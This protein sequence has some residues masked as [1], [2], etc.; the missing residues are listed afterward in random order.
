VAKIDYTHMALKGITK[1]RFVVSQIR[2]W[3][4]EY[5]MVI[6]AGPRKVGKT[7]ALLQLAAE[8]N[9][10]G[11]VYLNCAI[12]S[13]ANQIENLIDDGFRGLLLLDEFHMLDDPNT[14][15]HMF[16]TFGEQNPRFRVVLT[17]SVSSSMILLAQMKGGGRNRLL[18]IPLLTY[19]EY[20][21]FTDRIS[22]YNVD[23]TSV[24]FG[25]SF[26]DYISL[27][28]LQG[29]K[30][31]R[32][33]SSYITDASQEIQLAREMSSYLASLLNSNESDIQRAL[34]LLAYKL[35]G[36][37][38]LD[39]TFK[40]PKVG[41]FEIGR[42]TVAEQL[43]EKNIFSDFSVWKATHPSMGASQIEE[44]LRYLLW[45]EL[46]LC[47]FAMEDINS[48]LDLSFLTKL[49]L[50]KSLSENDLRRFF[51]PDIQLYVVNPLWY[52]LVAEELWFTLEG[53][54]T[55]NK[56]DRIFTKLARLL[57]DRNTFLEDPHIIGNWVEAYLRGAYAL[58]RATPLVTASFQDPTGKEIDIVQ[59]FPVN[60]LIEVAVKTR[61][62]K[63]KD[64]NFH[65]AYTGIEKCFVTTKDILE[66]VNWNG[67]PIWRI[68]YPM[69]A[70]FLD[71]GEV[72]SEEV[73]LRG[74]GQ[75]RDDASPRFG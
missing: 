15:M 14:Y 5:P 49:Y 6:L 37:W 47:N 10:K 20:L 2:R 65:L 21:Y 34:L 19:L 51:S 32:I 29:F 26:L 18:H 11:A 38:D 9:S 54:V 35:T 70:V 13:D 43:R 66:K 60:V 67:V 25:D 3:L 44:S 61:E 68:P 17:G 31:P 23:L 69:L 50:G 33:D 72:P 62:K 71:R 4:P 39:Q 27:K 41:N 53:L 52:S 45:S 59:G 22:D 75:A 8:F 28:D 63:A 57:K 46:A 40:N 42:A 30:L 55:T 24:D 64:V 1:E 12:P 16:N 7:V 56:N 74:S 36:M 58:M 73:L 48:R